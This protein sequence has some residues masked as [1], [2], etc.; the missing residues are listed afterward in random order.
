MAIASPP[1]SHSLRSKTLIEIFSFIM[2]RSIGLFRFS[3]YSF[4]FASPYDMDFLID[5]PTKE[6]SLYKKLD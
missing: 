6:A 1:E 4:P 5:S 2:A 3:A